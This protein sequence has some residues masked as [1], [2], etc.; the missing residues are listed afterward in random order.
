MQ[1]TSPIKGA[2]LFFCIAYRG[3]LFYQEP[4]ILYTGYSWIMQVATLKDKCS[5]QW[6][7]RIVNVQELP[8]QVTCLRI[9]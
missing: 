9:R 6:L 5:Y 4:V 2:G 1:D 3:Q 7:P 8:R